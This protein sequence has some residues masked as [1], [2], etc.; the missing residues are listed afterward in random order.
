MSF[1]GARAVLVLCPILLAACGAKTLDF[2][3]PDGGPGDAGNTAGSGGSSGGTT[4]TGGATGGNTGTGATGGS[5]GTGG[6][7]GSGGANPGDG[8][9]L[10][11]FVT[12]AHRPKPTKIDL[13]FMI[14][15]SS[16]MTDK[17]NILSAAVP[18]L[19]DALIDPR[20]IDPITDR[21]I[22][23]AMNGTCPPGSVLAFEPIKDIHIGII[24]SS[25]GG[26]GAQG[27]C[28]DAV[29][30][31]LEPHN[32][33][34]G[35]LLTRGSG[36]STVPTFLNKGFLYF[37]PA[38][39]STPGSKEAV[40][41]RFVELVR[42]V[43]QHGCK[44]EASLEAAYRFLIDPEPFDK[45][46]IDTSIGGYGAA[47][48]QG[49]DQTL[50]QQR[51]DFLRP[52]SV[53]SLVVVTDENDC[54]VVDGGQG[55][56]PL[57]PPV[58]NTG[59]GV[60]K[61]GTSKCFENPND[62][63]C[64]NC[65]V[66]TPPAG[67]GDTASDPQCQ[68]GELLIAEDQPNLRC[69]NQKQRYGVDFLYPVQRYIDGFTSMQVPN[70]RGEQVQNPLF[71]DLTCPS[72]SSARDKS[73]VLVTGIV[74]VP[75]QDI[76]A[77]PND[78]TNGYK[79]AQQ[80]R[81]E[82][83]WATI[84]G[85]PLNPLGPVPPRDPHMVESIKPR[86]GLAGP[87]GGHRA[88]PIHGHEWD[89]SRIQG[90]PNSDLQ[91]ACIF[92][93]SPPRTCIEASDCDCFGPNLDELKNPVCQ[94]QQ[95]AYT[96]TQ[97]HAKAYPGTRILQV[98]QGIGDQAI[99]GSICPANVR[100]KT[101]DD[102]GFAPAVRGII[103]KLR[104]LVREPCSPEV[105]PVHATNGQT[106]CRIIEVFNTSSC[107]CNTEPGRITASDDVLTDEMKAFG[108]CRCEIMQL[109]GPA[110]SACLA[111]VNPGPDTPSGWCYVD[112]AQQSD[113]SCEL[114]R[115]CPADQQRRI[116]FIS[117]DSEPRPGATAFLN[118][119]LPPSAPFP[120]RCP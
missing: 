37:N 57:L 9:P 44:Y 34:R 17:Q 50:L 88:D 40:A 31:R 90:A 51:A 63:C 87:E 46:A 39:S 84:L 27:V 85:D 29:D 83:I 105:L 48:L 52:D 45:V 26:H 108:N 11:P 10:G 100:E 120:S 61:S 66:Q 47:M 103:Q 56:Y 14:D 107:T 12:K 74:G 32:D 13:L 8:G 33:D 72:C 18:D 109:S 116:R 42:G 67:C 30:T 25:L 16:S 55:F 114:V 117:R 2:N 80:L 113:A 15:N 53:V 98:L 70:R 19:V 102:F 78:L 73:F 64:F 7:A 111:Q 75:W 22:A 112:P 101:R 3:G 6:S 110:Q 68:K 77:N 20:C 119:A 65:G 81:A 96:T 97:L 99:V 36:G 69:F 38:L 92:E 82:N 62:R 5:T 93:I 24:S 60:L 4:G 118:C 106:A 49:I 71:A 43:G 1:Q 86:V 35:H 54:S 91:Y 89:P 95:G 59:R 94:N 21:T 115:S 58:P 28:E 23:S 79:T 104:S 41:P 76:A